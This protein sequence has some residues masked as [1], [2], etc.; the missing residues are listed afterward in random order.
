[1]SLG[2]D[3]WYALE[4]YVAVTSNTFQFGAAVTLEAS[5]EF[6]TVTYTARGYVSFDVLL[7][8]DP[9]SFAAGFTAQVSITAGSADEEL[10]AVNLHARLEGPDPWYATGTARFTFLGVAVGFEFAAGTPEQVEAPDRVS[11]IDLVVAALADATAW[12]PATPPAGSPVELAAAPDEDARGPLRLRPDSDLTV[13]QQVAPLDRDLDGYG[14]ARI[15]GPTRL[16]LDGAGITAARAV[17][18]TSVDS[19]FP[20][21]QFDE[22]T[23]AQRLSAPSYELMTAGSRISAGGLSWGRETQSVTPD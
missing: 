1:V 7:T 6:L 10:L 22:L 5:A 19:W 15:D 8:F 2:S 20:P 18:A 17:T 12:A 13:S 3:V 11:V 9:F 16:T 23:A 14:T 4:C 21:A